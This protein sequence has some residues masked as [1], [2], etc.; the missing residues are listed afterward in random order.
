MPPTGHRVLVAELRARGRE[1]VIERID[2]A[3]RGFRKPHDPQGRLAVSPRALRP[4]AG[5]VVVRG[6]SPAACNR[7]VILFNTSLTVFPRL[8]I[9][10]SAWEAL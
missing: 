2:G 5:L 6:S 10:L 4:R 9:R 3:D 7:Q 1:V 8:L